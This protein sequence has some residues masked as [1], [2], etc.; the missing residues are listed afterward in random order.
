MLTHTHTQTHTFK[1]NTRSSFMLWEAFYWH[2]YKPPITKSNISIQSYSHLSSSYP[3]SY[4]QTFH[5]FISSFLIA[6]VFPGSQHPQPSKHHLWDYLLGDWCS[7]LQQG[8]KDLQY[9]CQGTLKLF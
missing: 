3:S 8:Y 9:I 5:C 2:G 1:G 6:M 7:T 4:S